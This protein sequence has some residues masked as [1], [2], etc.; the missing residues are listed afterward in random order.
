MFLSQVYLP[1]QVAEEQPHGVLVWF[2]QLLDQFLNS[3][4]FMFVFFDFCSEKQKYLNLVQYSHRLTYM[5]ID[6]IQ[7]LTCSI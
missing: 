5:V 1:V 6:N 4:N 2:G 3:L 7:C